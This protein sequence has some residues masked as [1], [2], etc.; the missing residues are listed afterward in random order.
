MTTSRRVAGLM[1]ALALSA[2]LTAGAAPAI[3]QDADLDALG[4]QLVDEFI[5]ILKQPEEAKQAGLEDFL[6]SEFQIVRDSGARLDQAGYIANPSTVFEVEI[7]DL[8]ATESDGVLV[9][10]YTLAV[11]EVIDG[12]AIKTVRPRLSVFHLGDDGRWRIAAHANF[13]TLPEDG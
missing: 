4:T 3:A 5:E 11:D 12:E 13:G 6:A 8:V 2:L 1:A 10:S 7:F 9:A